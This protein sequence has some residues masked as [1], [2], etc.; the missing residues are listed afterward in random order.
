MGTHITPS[1]VVARI[2][3]I[4]RD[5]A[6]VLIGTALVPYALQFVV[7]LLLAGPAGFLT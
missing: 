2:W 7:F 5:Q 6:A 4:Y 1:A 3:E